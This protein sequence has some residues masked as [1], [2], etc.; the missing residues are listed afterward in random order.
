MLCTHRLSL[1]ATSPALDVSRCATRDALSWR[2][3]ALPGPT[4]LRLRRCCAALHDAAP[5]GGI[6][7]CSRAAT[8]LARGDSALR[9][10]CCFAAEAGRSRSGDPAG[11]WRRPAP[12]LHRSRYGPVSLP[13]LATGRLLMVCQARS[14]AAASPLAALHSEAVSLVR[15][16]IARARGRRRALRA[17]ALRGGRHGTSV[18]CAAPWPASASRRPCCSSRCCC[19]PCRC[20]QVRVRRSTGGVLLRWAHAPCSRRRH[21]VALAGRC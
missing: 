11:A 16:I 12:G 18:R 4:A 6:A 13:E 17:C 3:A 9:R 5:H 8:L 15:C 21:C 10:G 2:A 19:R 14:A 1:H 7:A 20:T